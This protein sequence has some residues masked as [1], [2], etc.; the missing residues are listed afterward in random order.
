MSRCEQIASWKIIEL[1]EAAGFHVRSATRADCT[2]CHG[3]SSGTVG[4]DEAKGVAHCFRCG[5]AASRQSLARDLGWV[6]PCTLSARD[7]ARVR[8]EQETLTRDAVTLLTAEHAMYLRVRTALLRLEAIRRSASRRLC[9]IHSGDREHFRGEEELAWEALTYV[10]AKLPRAA[11]VCGIASFTSHH[12]RI[13]FA[14]R[15]SMRAQMIDRVLEDGF[16]TNGRG[17]KIELLLP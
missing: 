6:K 3:T 14:L 9:E 15:P 12:E 4:F 5:W 17:H 1:L 11:A 2:K 8:R 16:V 10:Y 7:R 13:R